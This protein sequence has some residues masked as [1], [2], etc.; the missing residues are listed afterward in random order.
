LNDSWLDNVENTV[1]D[2]GATA[3]AKA[4]LAIRVE[5]SKTEKNGPAELDELP[6]LV[7][8]GFH[9]YTCDHCAA[10]DH[11]LFKDFRERWIAAGRGR[12]RHHDYPVHSGYHARRAPL[13]ANAIAMAYPPAPFAKSATDP[14]FAK[15][16][17]LLIEHRGDWSDTGRFG[18]ILQAA[19]PTLDE[20]VLR[21]VLATGEPRAELSRD[22]QRMK[23]WV[24]TT[25]VPSVV[26]FYRDKKIGVLDSAD[27]DGLGR[28]AAR[29]MLGAGVERSMTVGPID[30]DS[31][32]A[33]A[34][35]NTGDRITNAMGRAVSRTGDL[36]DVFL[37]A[38]NTP[39]TLQVTR[40]GA[41]VAVTLTLR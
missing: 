30:P 35:L 38:G 23:E 31:P 13:I 6:P 15:A 9:D 26:L 41:P 7:L 1:K 32:A 5:S 12:I 18:A 14:T 34:G 27:W 25:N 33:R 11:T 3:Q 37:Q 29:A 8:H 19:M 39:I 2:T 36:L 4:D 40:A 24:G 22:E 28:A 17:T 20:H 16:Y 10:V 21:D